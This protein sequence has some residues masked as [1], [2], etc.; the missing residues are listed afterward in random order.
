MQMTFMNT[1]ISQ[2]T[3][4]PH[5]VLAR[6]TK[7]AVRNHQNVRGKGDSST[8]TVTATTHGHG[9]AVNQSHSSMGNL[10]NTIG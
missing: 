6:L 10:S 7:D 8:S 9:A 1:W 5:S 2:H 3:A 4:G